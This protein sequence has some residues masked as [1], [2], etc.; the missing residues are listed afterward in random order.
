[1]LKTATAIVNFCNFYGVL[2]TVFSCLFTKDK[3]DTVGRTCERKKERL[4][5]ADGGLNTGVFA[6]KTGYGHPKLFEFRQSNTF[7]NLRARSNVLRGIGGPKVSNNPP[8]EIY[9]FMKH[10]T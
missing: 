5:M 7:F 1:M 4:K 10:E 3:V 9:Y 2:Y 8:P 6:W